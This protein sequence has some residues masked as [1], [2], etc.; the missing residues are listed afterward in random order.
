MSYCVT[1][2][3][4]LNSKIVDPGNQYEIIHDRI[5]LYHKLIAFFVTYE[6][7]TRGAICLLT[8]SR[9]FFKGVIAK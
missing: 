1:R 9:H 8:F 2:F 6:V 4:N 5:N 7:S 3:C